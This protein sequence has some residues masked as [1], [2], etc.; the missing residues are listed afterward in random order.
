V[1]FGDCQG[2]Y[3]V[4]GGE[5]T[6]RSWWLVASRVKPALGGSLINKQCPFAPLCALG[7]DVISI[8]RQHHPLL[9]LVSS[10]ANGPQGLKTVQELSFWS[11]RFFFYFSVRNAVGCRG[12]A[13][14]SRGGGTFASAPKQI[15]SSVI[16]PSHHF[17]STSR[18]AVQKLLPLV[19]S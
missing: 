10:S 7:C 19:F 16:I 1:I 17:P 5:N 14:W 18:W 3:Y 6:G 12:R 4:L 8:C 13:R 11:P 15:E 9:V 2:D